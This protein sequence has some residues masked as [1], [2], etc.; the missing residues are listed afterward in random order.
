MLT[1][2]VLL[3]GGFAFAVVM[4]AWAALVGTGGEH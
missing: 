2:Y 1:P 3:A 4:V